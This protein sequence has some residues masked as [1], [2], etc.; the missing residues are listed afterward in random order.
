MHSARTRDVRQRLAGLHARGA[1]LAE[2]VGA[3]KQ[4][5]ATRPRDEQQKLFHDNAE[6]FYRLEGEE[7][8]GK[9]E[10]QEIEEVTWRARRNKLF[11]SKDRGRDDRLGSAAPP[12]E[13][14]VR[15]SRI[16]L[17]GWQFTAERID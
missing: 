15:F 3:L 9:Q 10:G 1:T 16:R 2:W 12:S 6:R 5:V 17:S 4:I 13:P 11:D 8:Q 7:A 14:H